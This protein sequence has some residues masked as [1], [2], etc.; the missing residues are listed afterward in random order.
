MKNNKIKKIN[1]IHQTLVQD[2]SINKPKI[3]VLALNP[4]AGDNGV[5]GNEDDKVLKPT[6]KKLF[7]VVYERWLI[8]SILKI[9]G[10]YFL[11]EF[12]KSL[13]FFKI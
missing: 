11:K 2:F 5:I 10:F 12:K 3:A 8:I 9:I 6:I 7:V 13:I 1:V 4:H